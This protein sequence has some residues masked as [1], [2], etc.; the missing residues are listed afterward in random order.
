[1]QILDVLQYAILMSFPVTEDKNWQPAK[2]SRHSCISC[3]KCFLLKEYL[4]THKLAANFFNNRICH[5]YLCFQL[6]LENVFFLLENR[7]CWVHIPFQ[8][9]FGWVMNLPFYHCVHHFLLF[10]QQSQ[11]SANIYSSFHLEF[12]SSGKRNRLRE[13]QGFVLL[14]Q[15][16]EGGGGNSS[17]ERKTMTPCLTG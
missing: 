17:V 15:K 12:F 4:Q 5:K 14:F 1:M 8:D 7:Q 10:L 3:P 13:L 2:L 6:L 16:W 9:P 11:R